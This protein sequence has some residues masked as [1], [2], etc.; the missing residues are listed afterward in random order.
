MLFRDYTATKVVYHVVTITDLEK[1]LKNGIRFHDKATY[2]SKYHEFHSFFDERK[3]DRLPDWVMRSKSVFASLNFKNDHIWHSHSAVLSIKIKE[4]LCWVCNENIANFLYEPLMLGH[5]E[6]FDSAKEFIIKKG[7]RVAED[8]WNCSLSFIENLKQRKDKKAGYDAEVLI[9]H[10]ILP[11]DI[12]LLFIASDHR[13]MEAN[14]WKD[15]FQSNQLN[16][17]NC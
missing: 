16:Y 6:G 1:T 12:E 8:Y 14:K 15:F 3:P 7:S 11:K 9:M 2:K 17:T 4:D 5:V 10:D 13:C